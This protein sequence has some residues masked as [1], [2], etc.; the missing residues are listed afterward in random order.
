[1]TPRLIACC[2]LILSLST[3]PALAGGGGDGGGDR[4]KPEKREAPKEVTETPFATSKDL[5][6]ASSQLEACEERFHNL[7]G[8]HLFLIDKL[9]EIDKKLAGSLLKSTRE[10]TRKERR[11]LKDDMRDTRKRIRQ[12]NAKC[13][14]IRRRI[15]ALRGQ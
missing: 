15:A 2:T 9:E 1:M 7:R 13:D 3:T 8:F 12:Q 11:E 6:E 14:E 4:D 5:S 10:R